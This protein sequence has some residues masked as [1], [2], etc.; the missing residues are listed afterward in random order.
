MNNCVAEYVCDLF[1]R[2]YANTG[3][4]FYTWGDTVYATSSTQGAGHVCVAHHNN[5]MWMVLGPV[6][7]MVEL[8]L[9]DE[10]F[11]AATIRGCCRLLL[12]RDFHGEEGK[13]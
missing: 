8:D 6:V 5:N 11:A 7:G 9:H 4:S 2:I 3:L 12:C 10:E 13:L 1:R